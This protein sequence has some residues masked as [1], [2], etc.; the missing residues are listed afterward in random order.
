[1][2]TVLS[3]ARGTGKLDDQ[4]DIGREH[5]DDSR[6]A[7]VCR[8]CA[9]GVGQ[10]DRL[11]SPVVRI[12]S[13]GGL[14][15]L[16]RSSADASGALRSTMPNGESSTIFSLQTVDSS[17]DEVFTSLWLTDRCSIS[18]PSEGLEGGYDAPR[19]VSRG[20][21]EASMGR[22]GPAGR[23]SLYSHRAL[24]RTPS[25]APQAEISLVGHACS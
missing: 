13:R 23:R 1:M 21:P 12:W 20:N 4:G 8:L 2:G 17:S 19:E 6:A 10:Q 14:P 24:P 5:R 9:A 3:C 16:C 22:T 7:S 18:A 11:G 25:A 15:V